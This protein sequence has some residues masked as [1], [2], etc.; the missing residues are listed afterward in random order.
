MERREIELIPREIEEAKKE[1]KGLRAVRLIGFGILGL[2]I[3]I[4]VVLS[5]VAGGQMLL[6]KNLQ[7]KISE[8]EARIGE[9]TAIE[10]KVGSLAD[11]NDALTQI[12]RGRRYYSVLYEALEKSIPSGIEVTG[13]SADAA[14]SVVGLSG[15]TQ[16]Y[17][18]LAKF[19]ENLVD[20]A[21]GGAVFTEVALT[22]VVFDPEKGEAQFAAEAKVLEASLE[23]GWEGIL[24]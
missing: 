6:T 10:E 3:L 19:L 21:L 4:A 20:P 18:D 16:S 17:L 14:K 7:G 13:T 15:K 22:S 12:F 1:E 24:E 11:K 5:S 23:K 9:L 8:R 2:S